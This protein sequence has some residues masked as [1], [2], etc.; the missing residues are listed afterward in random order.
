MGTI[1]KC[2]Q[3]EA[4]AHNLLHPNQFGGIIGHSASDAA[5]LFTEHSYQAKLQ[6]L[7]TSVL[8]VDIAQFFPSIKPHIAVK[9]YCRQGFAEHLVQFLGS[10][11]S[12]RTTSYTL[13]LS[14]SDLFDM[15]SGIPQGCKICPITACLYIAPIL[16]TLLPWD[17]QSQKLLLSFIDDTA[18]A[19]SSHSLEANI[20]YLQ[21]Q[22]PRWKTHFQQ[23]GLNLEDD[24]TGLF[25]VWAYNMHL[26]GKPLFKGPLPSINLG[27]QAQPLIIT[28]N[29]CGT[30]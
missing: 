25:H 5:L 4:W 6:G 12:D 22:Y 30:T 27:T 1:A 19:V 18:L 13:G 3:Y 28:H 8:A 17:H 29:P 2:L 15:N 26:L 14:I 24:K 16:K 23:L 11:L 21:N 7:F 10:Y 9:I 20:A